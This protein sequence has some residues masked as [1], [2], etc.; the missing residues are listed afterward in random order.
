MEAL[1]AVLLFLGSLLCLSFLYS[2]LGLLVYILATG[3]VTAMGLFAPPPG[4]WR[5]LG[6]LARLGYAGF[7][8][9]M[10]FLLIVW[11]MRLSW[12]MPFWTVALVVLLS[13]GAVATLLRPGLGVRIPFTLPIGIAIITCL[14]GW[15]REEGY[16]RCDDYVRAGNQPGVEILVPTVAALNGCTPGASFPIMRYPRKIWE[17]PD[18]NRYVVTTTFAS[19]PPPDQDIPAGAYDGLFCEIYADASHPPRCLGGLFGKAHQI[20][21]V[22]S[23][24]QFFSCAWGLRSN[25]GRRTSAVFRLSRSAP[26]TIL[27]ERRFYDIA[28]MYGVYEPVGDVYHP[29]TDECDG[30]ILSLRGEDFS[31][32]ETL[33]VPTCPGQTLYDPDLDR[34]VMCGG[35]DLFSGFTLRPWSYRVIAREGALTSPVWLSWGCDWDPQHKTVYA[36]IANL[37]LLAA[38]DAESGRVVDTRFVGFALRA[39]A[40]DAPRGRVYLSDFLAGDVFAID[41]ESGEEVARWFAGHYLRELRLSRDGDTLLTASNLGVVRIALD[42]KPD[43]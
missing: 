3:A 15:R 1:N 12:T 31:S 36:T 19:D 43:I 9:F 7:F 10:V 8:A 25:G 41:L 22:D 17:A 2:G 40:V 33:P 20:E 18:A 30:P 27:Q 21:E 23:R 24:D 29:L 16:V 42:P 14:L 39:V 13:L 11:G 37:G 35:F 28:L 5:V 6:T 32:L 4:R 34:G 26:L 38:I